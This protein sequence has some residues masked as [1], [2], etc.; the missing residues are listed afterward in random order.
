MKNFIIAFFF[1]TTVFVQVAQADE[2]AEQELK[3][4][5]AE[6]KALSETVRKLNVIVE[7]QQQQLSGIKGS[8]SI[9]KSQN[10]ELRQ[11]ERQEVS[12][13]SEAKATGTKSALPFIP[14][15]GV[16]ADITATAT[17]SSED[18][19]GNDRLSVR[20]VELIF[21]HDIDPYA[22]LDA[23]LTF[24]DFEDPE[25]EEAYASYW[26]LPGDSNGRIG[27]FRPKIGK[28]SALHRDSLDTVDEPLV[29][30]RYLGV[31]GLFKT[32]L[33]LSSFIPLPTES[34]TEQITL[35]VIEG[36][37]GED[38]EM[39]GETRRRLSYYAHLSNFL[40]ISEDQ[41]FEL[42]GTY[43]LGSQDED[44]SY[45][46]NAFAGDITYLHYLTPISKFKLQTEIFVQDR[47]ETTAT[48]EEGTIITF[49]DHP[50]GFYALADYR[51]NQRWGFGGR[52]DYV[53]P[54]ADSPDNLRNRD[55][56]WTGYL[57]FYQSE[58]ARW[59]GQY[60]YA[61]LADGN[62]DNRFYLQ[63]TFSIGT[64]KHQLQ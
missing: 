10:T 31:E 34:F 5:K 39:F 29:I 12:A 35:G 20:E 60:S 36:G 40:D 14:D 52:Y 13:P 21:G 15:I 4:L 50:L 57:T 30:Q 27:R 9:Q 37:V 19:E 49:N 16:I 42:G 43:L 11:T 8:S 24:S 56:A 58:F 61:R 64:H 46:V 62:D 54:T 47:S 33:E 25:I 28:A 44:S 6:V 45:E 53:E 41:S 3:Q 22:R 48:A 55:I 32:G 63:G 2:S 17:E 23:T 1:L 38:G 7:Q 18:E 26:G 59:R 51:L